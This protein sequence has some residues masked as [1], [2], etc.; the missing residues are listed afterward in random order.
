MIFEYKYH[1]KPLVKKNTVRIIL[2]VCNASCQLYSVILVSVLACQ[3]FMYKQ[4][5]FL[6][7]TRQY[8]QLEVYNNK[9]LKFNSLL[10]SYIEISAAIYGAHIKF[11]K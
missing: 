9:I 2:T 4:L 10:C 8:Q 5:L 7:L 6:K 1:R 3:I 11:P